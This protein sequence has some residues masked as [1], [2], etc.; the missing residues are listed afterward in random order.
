MNKILAID[1]GNISSAF[2]VWDGN[3]ILDKGILLNH[4]LLEYIYRKH[5]DV[6]VIERIQSFGMSVGETIFESTHWAGRFHEAAESSG[7]KVIRIPRKDVKMNLCSS[8]RAKDTNIRQAIIDRLVPGTP[9]GKKPQGI[10][11]GVHADEWSA[12]G[13]AL[14]YQDLNIYN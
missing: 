13:L 5:Y 7:K 6:C 10:L 1:N 2:L 4:E 12:L 3:E 8:M 9:I 11:K 14:T